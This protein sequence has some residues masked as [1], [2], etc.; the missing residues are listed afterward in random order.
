MRIRDWIKDRQG[1][2]S[3]CEGRGSRSNILN[4]LLWLC[5]ITTI[6]GLYY[7]F[8]DSLHLLVQVVI[9]IPMIFTITAYTYF[10]F[11]DPDRLQTEEFQLTK[12]HLD[13]MENKGDKGPTIITADTT[14][15]IENPEKWQLET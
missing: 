4:P 1:Q 8:H 7:I 15:F 13:L 9:F 12:R 6:P 5:A 11:L 14:D 10:M 3:E 2:M